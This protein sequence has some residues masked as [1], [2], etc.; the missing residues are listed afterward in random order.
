M[1]TRSRLR[2]WHVWLGWVIALP[3]LFWVISGLVMVS[4]PI[5]EVR[6]EHLVREPGPIRLALPPVPPAVAGLPM[7]SMS[8][9]QRADGPR[10][11]IALADGTSRLADPATGALLPPLSAAD[12]VREV[13]AR[14]TGKARVKSATRTD[15]DKPPLELRRPVAAW[16][17]AMDDDTRFYVDSGSGQIVA[18]RTPWWRFY[19]FMWGLHIMDLKTREDM[20]NPLVIGFAIVALV[21]SI[22]AMILLPLTINRRRRRAIRQD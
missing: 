19:D 22:L 20:H 15:P 3:I 21:M 7:K 12:A 9:E 13:T 18:R 2:R 8:L 5:E 1:I 14:Y 16:L 11:V 17:V 10:W 4:K 6:G